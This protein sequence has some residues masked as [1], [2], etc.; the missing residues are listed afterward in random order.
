MTQKRSL[1][2]QTIVEEAVA[3]ID[4]E[5]VEALSMAHLAKRLHIR[6][7][8]LYH[9][10]ND[11]Q[12]LRQ[13]VAQYGLTELYQA[14]LKAS[15]GKAKED[16]LMAIGN[17]YLTFARKRPGLYEAIF[18]APA[19]EKVGEDIVSLILTILEPFPLDETEKIHVVRGFRSLLHG[20]T[21]IEKSDG[22]QIPISV[23]ESIS[24]VL[25][26]YVKGVILKG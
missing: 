6:P 22:F 3:L 16:A 24:Y 9:H 26:R 5:G 15:A 17:A 12:E 8:S 23:D 13:N 19:R 4:E 11:L 1:T 7:P 20:F 2:I 25:E 21:T 10:I 14:M 18:L